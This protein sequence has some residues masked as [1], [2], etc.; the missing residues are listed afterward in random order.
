MK[1]GI[2]KYQNKL[3]G[4]IY[5]GQSINIDRRYAQHLYDAEHRPERSTGIDKA[6]AKY[7]IENFDFSIVEECS[8]EQLDE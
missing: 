3:N 4:H 2:Y 8:V 6:I 5:I 7:G 1:T